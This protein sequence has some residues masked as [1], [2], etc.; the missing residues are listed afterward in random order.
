VARPR[1]QPAGASRQVKAAYPPVLSPRALSAV[2]RAS[3]TA[4]L[5]E[6]I[7]TAAGDLADH[8]NQIR[9]AQ[10][11]EGTPHPACVQRGP[12]QSVGAN[13]GAFVCVCVDRSHPSCSC[14]RLR[15][16]RPFCSWRFSAPCSSG[17]CPH[18]AVARVGRAAVR[19]TNRNIACASRAVFRS[20]RKIAEP[21]NMAE[22]QP[23]V[24]P[25]EVKTRRCTIHA[26]RYRW[27]I[28]ERGKTVQ[29]SSESFETRDEAAAAGQAELANLVEKGR[30]GR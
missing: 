18:C 21:R 17:S 4:S 9:T 26:G 23:R 25:Y 20:T 12:S 19:Q 1:S 7:L 8:A 14:L 5:C 24:P 28:R 11:R 6:L 29:S 15:S 27:D 30:I 22:Q 2:V 13:C 10:V 3:F 16:P